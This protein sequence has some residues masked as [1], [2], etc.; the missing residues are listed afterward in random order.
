M[1]RTLAEHDL[2]LQPGETHAAEIVRPAGRSM[3]AC[4]T[5]GVGVRY[6]VQ[7]YGGDGWQV[8]AGGRCGG[9]TRVRCA[10][11]DEGTLCRVTFAA[12][13]MAN[14]SLRWEVR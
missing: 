7:V 9:S 4:L 6:A 1:R 14:V 5:G 10:S 2:T 13:D 11:P 3:Y 8:R 12:D